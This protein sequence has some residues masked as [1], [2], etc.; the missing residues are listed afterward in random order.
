[1][2]KLYRWFNLLLIA[3]IAI[4]AMSQKKEIIGYYPSW[5]WRTTPNHVMTP[6]LIPYQ[7]L[8]T[9]VYSF[10]KPLTD[11]TVTGRDSIGDELI[12]KGERDNQTGT[13]KPGT[14]LVELAHR[15]GIKV[16]VSVG[17]WDDSS[18]FP[19]I[20][21]SELA[22][23]QFAHSCVEQLRHF[24]FD[25]ID[26]DWEYPCFSEH[27]G[28]PADKQDY[29]KLLQATRDS[30]NVYGKET[31]NHYLL[32]AAL[33]AVETVTKNY[34][35]EKIAVLLD[36]LNV[37]TYD[38]NGEW[39]S[40]SGHNAPLYAPTSTDTVRNLD[41]AFKL[42][43]KKYKIPASKINLGVPFYGHTYKNCTALYAAHKGVDT[44]HFSS[45]GCFYADLVQSKETFIRKWDER[46][47]VP[48]L[49][50]PSWNE[51]ISYDDEE[52]VRCKAQYVNEN[53]ACG[54]IIWEITGDYLRDGSTPLLDVID[55]TFRK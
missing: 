48:Y 23:K 40:L 22:R 7:K 53:N 14:A 41:A 38:L 3:F 37:M 12:L 24:G 52:S 13:Y 42:Y 29:T 31:G 21:A 51:L 55:A 16:M 10:F 32:T 49:I 11:G 2:Q 28:T 18:N 5:K 30:L 35:M 44:T 26:I 43:T 47:K 54:L 4:P 17:G 9:I 46:A 8:T 25:G 1:M 19:E 27:Q 39:D 45:Q 15:H 33:P 50:N 36:M 34:E 20:A 6:V